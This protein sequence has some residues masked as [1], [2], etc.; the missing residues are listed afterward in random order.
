MNPRLVVS[1]W[2]VSLCT[3]HRMHQVIEGMEAIGFD[4]THVY[5]L[6]EVYGPAVS[7]PWQSQW[8]GLSTEARADIKAQQG[9][10][11]PFLEGCRV[12]TDDMTVDVPRDGT[13]LGEV[14][15]RG[16]VVMKGYLKDET[17]TESAFEGGERRAQKLDRPRPYPP[18]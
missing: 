17:A 18:G 3:T 14:L 8:D 13:T 15:M 5:G 6:T 1:H 11:Y 2:L 12:V 4:V 10:G 16:N 9:V 7:C